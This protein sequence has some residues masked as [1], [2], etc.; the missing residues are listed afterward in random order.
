MSMLKV[1]NTA[2][3]FKQQQQQ[4]GETKQESDCFWTAGQMSMLKV[5]NTVTLF[6]Q[7]QHRETKQEFDCFSTAEL[8]LTSNLGYQIACLYFI[9]PFYPR[10]RLF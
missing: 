2:T 8:T 1:D 3:L 9:S 6:K 4:H 7:Q 5:D 10:I